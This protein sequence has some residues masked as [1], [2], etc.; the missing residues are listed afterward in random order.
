MSETTEE[1]KRQVLNLKRKG[2]QQIAELES[3]LSQGTRLEASKMGSKLAGAED[4]LAEVKLLKSDLKVLSTGIPNLSP[5]RNH[6]PL[7][8]IE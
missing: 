2:T 8:V 5:L 1:F 7:I 6:N 4:A 3:R